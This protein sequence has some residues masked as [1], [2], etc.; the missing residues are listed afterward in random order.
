MVEK[1]SIGGKEL[2]GNLVHNTPGKAVGNCGDGA[3]QA[4]VVV[5]T[6]TNA[7]KKGGKE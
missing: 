6:P 1:A 2:T 7:A 5:P 3:P 4:G